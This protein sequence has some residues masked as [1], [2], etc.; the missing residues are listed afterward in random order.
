MLEWLPVTFCYDYLIGF[1]SIMVDTTRRFVRSSTRRDRGPTLSWS[2]FRSK[3][4][5]FWFIGWCVCVFVFRFSCYVGM[6]RQL[7]WMPSPKHIDEH[8]CNDNNHNYVTMWSLLASIDV[9]FLVL[10]EWCIIWGAKKQF[11]H[12]FREHK[13]ARTNSDTTEEV[14]VSPTNVDYE[15]WYGVVN[16]SSSLGNKNNTL[17]ESLILGVNNILNPGNENVK[18]VKLPGGSEYANGNEMEE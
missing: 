16:D 8:P 7:I 13:G 18:E 5:L 11:T 1:V 6:I 3:H 9:W 10:N 14:T 12:I 17:E 2:L 15:Y 4:W